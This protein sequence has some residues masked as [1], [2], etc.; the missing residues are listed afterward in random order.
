MKKLTYT[1]TFRHGATVETRI[2][3]PPMTTFSGDS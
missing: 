3:Q 1:V 2:V